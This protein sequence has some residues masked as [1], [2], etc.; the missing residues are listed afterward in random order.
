MPCP[1]G[2]MP[3]CQVCGQPLAPWRRANP[4]CGLPTCHVAYLHAQVRLR[5]EQERERQ[6]EQQRTALAQQRAA[7][8]EQ[9]RLLLEQEVAGRGEPVPKGIPLTLIPACTTPVTNLP[10]S[11]RHAFREWLHLLLDEMLRQGNAPGGEVTPTPFGP[12]RELSPA[13]L[14]VMGQACALCQGECCKTGADDAYLSRHVF[15]RYLDAHPE[16]RPE[17]VVTAYLERVPDRSYQ[18]SCVY[19][20][21][22]G[23]TLPR[24]MR[25]DTCNNYFCDGLQKFSIKTATQPAIRGYFVALERNTM[26]ASAF[27]HE[28][29]TVAVP[30][31][32]GARS[33]DGAEKRQAGG[34]AVDEVLAAHGA[35]LPGA[36]EAG[37]R[38]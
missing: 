33:R 16:L 12:K 2:T 10:E 20:G 31:D 13:A 22:Q 3:V 6:Q 18:G 26:H 35:Q 5:Q 36:E 25:S 8:V 23:C 17:D 15:R 24:A 34:V 4:I 1:Q 30:V 37:Q 28:H 29:G 11:R 21:P 14:A 7:L 19:H 32:G 9:A 38:Q 27:I